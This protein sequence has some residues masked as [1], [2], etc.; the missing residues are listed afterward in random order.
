MTNSNRFSEFLSHIDTSMSSDIKESS[1][2]EYQRQVFLTHL[3]TPSFE[4]QF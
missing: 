2:K 4:I 1:K 3:F